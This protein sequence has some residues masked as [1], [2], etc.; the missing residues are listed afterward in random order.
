MNTS[1]E[2]RRTA[3]KNVIRREG[4]KQAIPID[5]YPDA[6]SL[7]MEHSEHYAHWS[8][9]FAD[10]AGYLRDPNHVLMK[11]EWCQ[12]MQIT[13]EELEHYTP[14]HKSSGVTPLQVFAKPL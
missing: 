13:A 4:V 2:E 8:Q 1:T 9:N 3:F 5:E 6:Y 12:M 14:S 11:W 10:E 7:T